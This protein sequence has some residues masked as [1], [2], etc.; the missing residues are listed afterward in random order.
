MTKL[1]I[2]RRPVAA[3]GRGQPGHVPRL[4]RAEPRLCPGTGRRSGPKLIV[5]SQ[6]L[7][8]P[9]NKLHIGIFINITESIDIADVYI[10]VT[11]TLVAKISISYRFQNRDVALLAY[12][13]HP[14]PSA[15]YTAGK[16][17]TSCIMY[18]NV[19]VVRAACH[20]FH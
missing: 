7:K 8:S 3:P 20:S 11:N 1:K 6:R 15:L 18:V 17:I 19:T 13:H 14:S 12:S 10:S 5:L 9:E 16:L 2:C 4:E